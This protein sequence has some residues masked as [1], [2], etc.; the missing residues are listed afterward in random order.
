[1]FDDFEYLFKSRHQQVQLFGN[2]A[3][4]GICQT[5]FVV[6]SRSYSWPSKKLGNTEKYQFSMTVIKHLMKTWKLTFW[7]SL[8]IPAMKT[9]M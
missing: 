3:Q 4:T 7:K 6:P 9:I 1:M 5:S 2:S 8:G